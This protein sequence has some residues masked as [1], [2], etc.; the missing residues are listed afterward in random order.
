MPNEAGAWLGREAEA[1][2]RG[3]STGVAAPAAAEDPWLQLAPLGE[4][5]H[6]RG[7]QR[8]DPAAVQEMAR[9]F[10]SFRG[11]AG[12]LFGGL[13]FYIGHPDMPGA[14]ENADRKAYG[15][16][17]DLEARADGLYGRVKWSEAGLALLRD[18]HFKYCSPF[19]EAREI[20]IENGRRVY[21]PVAL[22]SAGLT[23]QPNIPVRPL[24]N[25][26][27]APEPPLSSP[28]AL[29]LHAASLTEGLGARAAELW[30]NTQR[31]DRIQD[32]VRKQMCDGLGYDEAWERVKRDH[33]ALF[34]E[35]L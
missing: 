32:L 31:G 26:S 9:Q 13:P 5:L 25:E 4:F 1:N 19:W 7:L 6:A 15:W 24:A 17:E 2:S 21:R 20:G 28:S 22:F 14:P 18:G 34:Q 8:V 33:A 16:I 23:N 11:R 12:R 10:H 29:P 30:R 35:C 27:A 3:C